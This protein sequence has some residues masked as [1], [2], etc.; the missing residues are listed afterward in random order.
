MFKSISTVSEWS[1]TEWDS[2]LLE[3]INNT[4][5]TISC[6]EV[7]WPISMSRH[8]STLLMSCVHDDEA[9]VILSSLAITTAVIEDKQIVSEHLDTILSRFKISPNNTK[10]HFM[11]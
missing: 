1:E 10:V 3:M 5:T 9:N 7:Q 2:L 4:V 8:L 6:H 11:H